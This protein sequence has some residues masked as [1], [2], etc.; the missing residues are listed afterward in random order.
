MKQ[1]AKSKGARNVEAGRARAAGPVADAVTRL[2]HERDQLKREL[3][4]AQQRIAELEAA[5]AQVLDRIDWAIDSLHNVIES[6][7]GQ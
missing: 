4:A 6:D 2:E 1:R 3:E 5:R 7:T